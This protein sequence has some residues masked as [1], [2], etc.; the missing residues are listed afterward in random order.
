MEGL[1]WGRNPT[2]VP[3]APDAD[4]AEL[5][6]ELRDLFSEHPAL[7]SAGP[8]KVHQD[9]C[10]LR[11]IRVDVFA[12]EAVLEALTADGEVLA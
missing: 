8:E 5:V 10:A 3:D 12:V 9:L 7:L 4:T 11:G 1:G 6:P 2:T